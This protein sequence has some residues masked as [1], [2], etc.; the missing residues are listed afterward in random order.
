[1]YNDNFMPLRLQVLAE[2]RQIRGYAH[3]ARMAL[4][5]MLAKEQRTV[6]SV[7]QELGVHPANITHHFKLLE[8]TGLIR[9]VEK[10]D[11][12]R[13]IEKYYRAAALSFAVH[14]QGKGLARKQALAL[15]I[16][17]D[18]LTAALDTVTGGKDG[19]VMA[20]LAAARVRPEEVDCFIAKLENLVK[21]FKTRKAKAGTV[22]NLN[23]SLY[24]NGIDRLAPNKVRL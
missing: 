18:D 13:N 7:A 22:Y 2:E 21:S 20:L 5:K 8:K 10:R 3:P 17:R 23:V 4:L 15:S 16:L 6:S 14:P 9:L 1:M 12:G 24:P 19:K 11:I